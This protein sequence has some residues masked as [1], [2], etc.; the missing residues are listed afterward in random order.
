MGPTQGAQKGPSWRGT[1]G[2]PQQLSVYR[3]WPRLCILAPDAMAVM[4]LLLSHGAG[5]PKKA[6]KLLPGQ[7]TLDGWLKPNRG[8][9]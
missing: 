2:G 3:L 7:T 6:P 9:G 4:L 5:A 1:C 8:R